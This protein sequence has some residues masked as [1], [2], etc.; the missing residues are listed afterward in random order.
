MEK[1]FSV[2]VGERI[3]AAR[4]ALKMTQAELA[5][6]M[7]ERM[8]KEVRPLTVTRLENGKRPIV[9]DELKAAAAALQVSAADLMADH[10]LDFEY[11][12]LVAAAEHKSR[13]KYRLEIAVRDFLSAEK[14]LNDLARIEH[15]AAK[16]PAA[17][18]LF[19]GQTLKTP[20]EGVV[21]QARRDWKADHDAEA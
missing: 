6:G 13:A 20:F 4:A 11:L 8:G 19:I 3:A 2:Q 15:D 18:R 12:A 21:K 17:T 14:A 16:L 1:I 7:S 10:D 5:H 9:V